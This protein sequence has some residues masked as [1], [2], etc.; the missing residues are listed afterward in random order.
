MMQFVVV[1][2]VQKGRVNYPERRLGK[3]QALGAGPGGRRAGVTA[4]E[5]ILGER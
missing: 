4:G 1:G 5:E 3:Y 2:E